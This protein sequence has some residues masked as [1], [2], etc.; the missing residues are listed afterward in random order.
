MA[1]TIMIVVPRIHISPLAPA[2][3]LGRPGYMWID[4]LRP[5][6][7]PTAVTVPVEQPTAVAA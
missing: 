4:A 2:Y 3:Y 1:N 5:Q 7:R 6:W